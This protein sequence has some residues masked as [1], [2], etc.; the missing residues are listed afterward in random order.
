MTLVDVGLSGPHQSQSL[1]EQF[2]VLQAHLPR[3]PLF[4]SV[5]GQHSLGH[6]EVFKRRATAR[7]RAWWGQAL[8]IRIRTRR[9]LRITTAPIFT[10]VIG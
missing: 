10:T 5:P 9:V 6:Y 2:E 7:Y 8:L 3:P 4:V 1:F